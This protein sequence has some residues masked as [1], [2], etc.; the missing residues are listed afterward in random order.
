MTFPSPVVTSVSVTT[1]ALD[2]VTRHTEPVHGPG[3]SSSSQP[4]SY[5]DGNS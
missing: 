1:S 3:P 4:G 2:Q 5:K